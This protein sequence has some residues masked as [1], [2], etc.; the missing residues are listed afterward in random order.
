MTVSNLKG[1]V[2]PVGDDTNDRYDST[3]E[4]RRPTEKNINV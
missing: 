3:P 1:L 2:P 4:I